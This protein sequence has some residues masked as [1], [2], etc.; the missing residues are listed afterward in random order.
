MP[1]VSQ[2]SRL[3]YEFSI[4]NYDDENCSSFNNSIIEK[5][6]CNKYIYK[7]INECCNYIANQKNVILNFCNNSVQYLCNDRKEEI[8]A[9]IND[10]Y[11]GFFIFGIII[12]IIILIIFCAKYSYYLHRKSSYKNTYTPINK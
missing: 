8:C 11:I 7:T 3:Y 12:F 6:Y 4:N 2:T 1:I 5:D 10:I 9:P